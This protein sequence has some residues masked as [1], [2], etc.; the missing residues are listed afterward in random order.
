MSP[1]PKRGQGDSAGPA[2][3]IPDGSL[4]ILALYAIVAAVSLP[5]LLAFGVLAM[6]GRWTRLGW[7]LGLAACIGL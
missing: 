6:L 2:D 7:Q 4:L 5:A 3:G 1:P